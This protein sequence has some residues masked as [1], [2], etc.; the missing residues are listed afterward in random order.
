M[1]RALV[2]IAIISAIAGCMRTV[3]L[4][5]QPDAQPDA[6]VPD[7]PNPDVPGDAAPSDGSSPD[8]PHD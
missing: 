1:K 4:D 7:G 8:V 6:G 5:P 2:V 3:V